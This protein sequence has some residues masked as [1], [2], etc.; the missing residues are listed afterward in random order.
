MKNIPIP[1][2]LVKEGK[3]RKQRKEKERRIGKEKVPIG[4]C[5]IA[6]EKNTYVQIPIHS[7]VKNIPN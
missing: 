5:R 2:E 7:F 4:K 3:K 6:P 1:K